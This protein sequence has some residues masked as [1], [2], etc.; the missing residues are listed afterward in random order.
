MKRV[1]VDKA[2]TDGYDVRLVVGDGT[3][4][5]EVFVASC[6]KDVKLDFVAAV[7]DNSFVLLKHSGRLH[8]RELFGA[9]RHDHACFAN[10]SVA[11]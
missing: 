11:D 7:L 8:L 10:G 1:L 2:E 9:V 3:H 5:L 6:V 4:A